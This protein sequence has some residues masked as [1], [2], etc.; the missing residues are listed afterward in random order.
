MKS[1][2]LIGAALLAYTA[3]M[4]V[5][6]RRDPGDL[7]QDVKAAD[8]AIDA[9]AMALRVEP[10]VSN[11]DALTASI[12]NCLNLR[13]QIGSVEIDRYIDCKPNLKGSK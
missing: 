1:F 9:A 2:L 12:N 3:V 6:Q 13:N 10:S 8:I 7:M 11:R 5:T 4:P